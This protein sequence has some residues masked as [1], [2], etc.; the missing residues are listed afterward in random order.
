VF[1]SFFRFVSKLI[2]LF[3]FFR[4]FQYGFETPKRT[5][6]KIFVWFRETNQ[7]SIEIDEF[8]FVLVRTVNFFVI[9][10]DTLVFMLFFFLVCFE[11]DLFVLVFSV[12]SKQ[13]KNTKMNRNKNFLVS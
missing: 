6:P 12:V 4:L 9:F 3:Q 8:C 7:K 1:Y 10:V 13:V 11:T 5:E 2:C